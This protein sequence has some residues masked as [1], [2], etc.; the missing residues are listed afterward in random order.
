MGSGLKGVGWGSCPPINLSPYLI[1]TVTHQHVF[2]VRVGTMLSCFQAGPSC[3]KIH[4]QDSNFEFKIDLKPAEY[5]YMYYTIQNKQNLQRENT[6][7]KNVI[8]LKIFPSLPDIVCCM[9]LAQRQLFPFRQTVK[10]LVV[11]AIS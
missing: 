2:F 5:I 11:P 6:Q 9:V 4:R 8:Y 3:T 7:T 1:L 10:S